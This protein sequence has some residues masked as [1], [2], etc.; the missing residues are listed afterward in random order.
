MKWAVD[1]SEKKGI[2]QLISP[3]F[4]KLYLKNIDPLPLAIPLFTRINYKRPLI[5]GRG[6]LSGMIQNTSNCSTS[7]RRSIDVGSWSWK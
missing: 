2:L 4:S 5:Y 1:L 7:P 6:R 3:L